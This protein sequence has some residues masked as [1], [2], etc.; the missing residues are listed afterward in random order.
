MTVSD[1]VIWE[2]VFDTFSSAFL[3]A[4]GQLFESALYLSRAREAIRACI[5]STNS[6]QPMPD[7]HVQRATYLVSIVATSLAQREQVSVLDF[8]GG[9]GIGYLVCCDRIP[10]ARSA[11]AYKIVDLP[12]ICAAGEEFFAESSHV[13]FAQEIHPSDAG[14]FEVAFTASALQYMP[15]WRV[16]VSEIASLRAPLVLLSDVFAGDIRPFVTLQLYHGS[17]TPHWFLNLDELVN[18]ME[19]HGY[20]L[21]LK[22]VSRGTRHGV[23]DR[24][25]MDNFPKERRIPFA[26]QLLF[27]LRE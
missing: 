18:V 26:W 5:E 25:P 22:D 24:L 10:A 6:G 4:K 12:E 14:R 17:K 27:G 8:G 2:G 20:V 21:L 19:Q 1:P 16:A 11:L 3:A 7:F 9:L 15:D 13:D 23:I